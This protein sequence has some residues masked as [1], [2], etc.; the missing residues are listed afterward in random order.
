MEA[1]FLR[2]GRPPCI[3]ARDALAPAFCSW[4][5]VEPFSLST[6]PE[7][8]LA[9]RENESIPDG[10]GLPAPL[11]SVSLRDRLRS[12]MRTV[13]AL[14]PLGGSAEVLPTSCARPPA[15]APR[16]EQLSKRQQVDW[17]GQPLRLTPG[18]PVALKLPLVLP[19]VPGLD[20]LQELAGVQHPVQVGVAAIHQVRDFA[21]A[22]RLCSG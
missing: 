13:R 20:E 4:V 12:S 3:S 2:T 16:Q 14:P 22:D 6:G 19:S 15:A 10:D 7:T 9:R 11:V 17:P 18:I 1:R 8:L 5:S 21:I